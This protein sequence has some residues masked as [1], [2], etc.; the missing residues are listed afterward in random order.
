MVPNTESN[1][2]FYFCPMWYRG[3]RSDFT[4]RKEN[5]ADAKYKFS[6]LEKWLLTKKWKIGSNLTRRKTVS[7]M[8]FVEFYSMAGEIQFKSKYS[9][10]QKSTYTYLVSIMYVGVL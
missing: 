5:S 9:Q 6:S 1:Q 3:H 10:E 8:T 2:H 7:V 4:R